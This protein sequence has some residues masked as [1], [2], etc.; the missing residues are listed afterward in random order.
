[1]D[2]FCFFTVCCWTQ[3]FE[4]LSSLCFL[5]Y[6]SVFLS[7]R[8]LVSIYF[9]INR[10]SVLFWVFLLGFTHLGYLKFVYILYGLFFSLA[11]SL[12]L[13]QWWLQVYSYFPFCVSI[14]FLPSVSSLSSLLSSP[15]S[16][17]FRSFMLVTVVPCA[18]VIFTLPPTVS[19]C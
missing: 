1:M 15:V 2:L 12:T 10:V 5:I 6:V 3:E 9:T 16:S 8:I 11:N 4:V 18:C 17:L 7:F 19:L 14:L 13:S